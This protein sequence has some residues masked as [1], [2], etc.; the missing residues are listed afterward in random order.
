MLPDYNILATDHS[1]LLDNPDKK[2]PF[3]DVENLDDN[4]DGAITMDDLIPAGKSYDLG[5]NI[6]RAKVVILPAENTSL[7]VGQ[8]RLYSYG[9]YGASNAEK[10][11]ALV[12]I[13]FKKRF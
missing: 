1:G 13:G 6:E 9:A 3:D 10:G 11:F 12:Q 7:K 4:G 2:K 5:N 8:S